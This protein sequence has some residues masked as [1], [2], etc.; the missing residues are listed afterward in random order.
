MFISIEPEL[1][2]DRD[3]VSATMLRPVE[4]FHYDRNVVSLTLLRRADKVSYVSAEEAFVG[5][6]GR[7]PF[8][9]S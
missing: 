9:S 7:A 2:Y 8:W 6:C 1:R 5:V 4:V 3:E